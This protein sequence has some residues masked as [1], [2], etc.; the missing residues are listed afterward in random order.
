MNNNTKFM[1]DIAPFLSEN[2]NEKLII[3]LKSIGLMRE[4]ICCTYCGHSMRWSRY[5][6]I[7]DGFI[8]RC[9]NINCT[10]VTTTRPIRTDSMFDLSSIYGQLKRQKN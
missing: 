1:K 10:F 4:S 7:H 6:K 8:W 2:N 9:D 3:Y 5:K